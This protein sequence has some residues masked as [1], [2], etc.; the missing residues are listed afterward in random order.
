MWAIVLNDILNG[1]I[2][3]VI[4]VAYSSVFPEKGSVR[5]P[6]VPLKLLENDQDMSLGHDTI[7]AAYIRQGEIS[8]GKRNHL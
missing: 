5:I 3:G 1:R 7:W 8:H 2:V 6:P 4:L